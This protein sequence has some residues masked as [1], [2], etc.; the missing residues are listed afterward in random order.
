MED[1]FPDAVS[2][3]SSVQ[4]EVEQPV[5]HEY[6]APTTRTILIKAAPEIFEPLFPRF[7]CSRLLCRDLK[8]GEILWNL[9][10][11]YEQ[12]GIPR[13]GVLAFVSNKYKTF[14][15]PFR[16]SPQPDRPGG[17]DFIKLDIVEFRHEFRQFASLLELCAQPLPAGRKNDLRDA[18]LS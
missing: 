16:S 12:D 13:S 14:F 3:V 11:L 15:D 4:A 1:E 7:R 9:P 17:I 5:F 6:T 8:P 10:F 2:A 18:E